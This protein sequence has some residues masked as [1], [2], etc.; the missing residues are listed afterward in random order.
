VGQEERTPARM[1]R[2]EGDSDSRDEPL[3][4][5]EQRETKIRLYGRQ[6]EIA[7]RPHVDEEIERYTQLDLSIVCPRAHYC[8]IESALVV[9]RARTRL[10]S[11]GSACTTLSLHQP[12]ICA[13]RESIF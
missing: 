8:D 11:T 7:L 5:R 2:K 1:M 13:M 3:A 6:A 9:E 10:S 12:H 4:A